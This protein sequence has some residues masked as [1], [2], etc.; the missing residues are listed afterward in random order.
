MDKK[1]VEGCILFSTPLSFVLSTAK[2]ETGSRKQS[3]TIRIDGLRGAL[4][5]SGN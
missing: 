2:G 4:R 5:T 3:E 1:G